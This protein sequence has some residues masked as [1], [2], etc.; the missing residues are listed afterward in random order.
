MYK[1]KASEIRLV[2]NN[3]NSDS[4]SSL[5]EQAMGA[6]LLTWKQRDQNT[7]R[8]WESGLSASCD[9]SDSFVYD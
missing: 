2:C 4:C 3:N 8:D 9:E 1:N 7:L 6:L 5:K